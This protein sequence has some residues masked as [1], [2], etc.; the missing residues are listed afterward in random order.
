MTNPKTTVR[1][2]GMKRHPPEEPQQSAGPLFDGVDFDGETY[3]R[4]RDH[5]RLAAQLAQVRGL[6]LDGD[7]RTL[8][9]ISLSVGAPE[10]SVSARLRDLRK[11][12]FGEYTV[13]RR[14]RGAGL[15]EYRIAGVSMLAGDG[16]K[17]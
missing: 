7:W 1:T 12:K 4:A 9:E 11:K 5:D 10:A 6:M 13:E 8:A 16:D 15:Y 2:H 14:Y 3:E 17:C